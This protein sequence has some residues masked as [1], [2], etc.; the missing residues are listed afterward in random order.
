MGGLPG[1]NDQEYYTRVMERLRHKQRGVSVWD[2]ERIV[3]QAFPQIGLASAWAH[4]QN[5]PLRPTHSPG[6]TTLVIFPALIPEG[7]PN[8]FQPRFPLSQLN[9]V[10]QALEGLIPPGMELEV[11]NPPYDSILVR[12]SVHF[13]AGL[14]PGYYLKQ[15]NSDLCQF[16]A[17][18]Q[19]QMGK[20]NPYDTL[21][22][23]ALIR[24]FI[25][26]LAY[27]AGVVEIQVFQYFETEGQRQYLEMGGDHDYLEPHLPWSILTSAPQH[28]LGDAQGAPPLGLGFVVNS[29]SPPRPDPGPVFPAKPVPVDVQEYLLIDWME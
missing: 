21:V 22:S 16:L 4:T 9:Q 10:S 27:I 2:L 15:L 20:I 17:P 14:D 18:W 5:T 3:L 11:I 28:L 19:T 13:A 25:N 29:P 8:P 26:G 7:L 1:E 6:K 12:A 24:G 23:P